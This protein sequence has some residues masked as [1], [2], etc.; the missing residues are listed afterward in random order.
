MKRFAILVLPVLAGCNGAIPGFHGN[1]LVPERGAVLPETA[2]SRL[3]MR[4][5]EA[6]ERNWTPAP[7]QIRQLESGLA[8]L[9]REALGPGGRIQRYYRQYAGIV[10]GGR[11]VV[12]VNGVS[13]EIVRS[14]Q[15]DTARWR[16]LPVDMLDG[17]TEQFHVRYD[18]ETC[19]FSGLAFNGPV[20]PSGSLTGAGPRRCAAPPDRS[21]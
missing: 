21:H 13:A 3:L 9:L 15:R 14:N 6:V 10:V 7:E 5:G 17:D 2:E 11:R 19:Q 8:Q 18:P 20:V 12:C 1:A 4:C 16:E